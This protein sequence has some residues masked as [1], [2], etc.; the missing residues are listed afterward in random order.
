MNIVIGYTDRPES[1]AALERAIEEAEARQATLHIVQLPT[2]GLSESASQAKE[3]HDD[4]Q[5][6]RQRGAELEERLRARGIDAHYDLVVD[7]SQT[8]SHDLLTFAKE[9]SA[10]LIVIGLRRRSPVGKVVLG[11]VSQKIL[12][13]A[14]CPVLAV[15]ASEDS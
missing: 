7:P 2:R 15:K 6:L 4:L 5:E 14:D 3:W 8:P 12:L 11:S 1:R 13:G 9:R 10:D